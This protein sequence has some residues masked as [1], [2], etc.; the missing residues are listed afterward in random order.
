MT[1]AT[2][3]PL[4]V[5]FYY[6]VLLVLASAT[7][8]PLLIVIVLFS[9]IIYSLLL[10][11]RKETFSNIL[12]DALVT[13]LIVLASAAFKHNGVTPLFFWNDQPVTKESLI[14][15]MALGGLVTTISFVYRNAIH[16]LPMDKLLFVGR[17]IWPTLGMGLSMAIRFVPLCKERFYRM[18]AAQKTI[19]YYATASSFDR[20]VGWVKTFYEAVIWTFD[21]CFH[22][23]DVMRARGYHLPHKTTF[24]LYSWH[25]SDFVLVVSLATVMSVFFA[26]YPNI[27]Y[28][29]FPQI[30][31]MQVPTIVLVVSLIMA[32]LPV[33][34]ELKERIKWHYYSSKM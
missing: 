4:A 11:G 12:Y 1:F 32:L 33:M 20:L 13:L 18:H 24:H 25:I 6:S 29:Y 14:W 8:Q 9:S 23:S 15:A 31:E 17:L 16:D 27:A 22:K 19:G 34:L 30:K 5:L 28:Y 7:K 26:I 10:Y 2:F 21:Q 3:H